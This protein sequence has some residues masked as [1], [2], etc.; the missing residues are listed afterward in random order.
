MPMR[1]L[2]TLLM[3]AASIAARADNHVLYE[4]VDQDGNKRF[5]NIHADARGCRVLNVAPINTMPPPKSQPKAS[6]TATPASFPRVDRDTQQQR[7]SQRR[8]ILE[9]ELSQEQGLLEQAKKELAAQE[10]TRLGSERNYQLVLD[11]LEPYKKKVKLHEDN[12]AN[13]RRELANAR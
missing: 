4:C 1:S 13:L 2:L 10:S 8:R 12:V 5:T 11:R 3:F 7:D 9:Q 6:A